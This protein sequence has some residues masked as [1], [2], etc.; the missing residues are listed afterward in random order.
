MDSRVLDTFKDIFFILRYFCFDFVL[1][2]CLFFL[3]LHYSLDNFH[4]L[5]L[6]SKENIFWIANTFW[7]LLSL[8][9]SPS[10]IMK[11]WEKINYNLKKIVYFYWNITNIQP[12]SQINENMGC[13][14]SNGYKHN[15]TLPNLQRMY[16]CKGHRKLKYF[17]V[18][19]NLVI[20]IISKS[21]DS[22]NCTLF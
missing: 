22:W 15:F 9:W 19:S 10:S 13:V 3:R 20:D 2:V 11:K 21:K 1:F 8:L 18:H 16:V 17:P 7:S 5:K 14:V 4:L 6:N 12:G